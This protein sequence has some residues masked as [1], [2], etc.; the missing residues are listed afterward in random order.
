MLEY[1]YEEQDTF[2]IKIASYQTKNQR[3]D[4]ETYNQ[5]VNLLFVW[6]LDSFLGGI[7]STNLPGSFVAQMYSRF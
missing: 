4:C 5:T 3:G 1:T 6:K 2:A 7:I